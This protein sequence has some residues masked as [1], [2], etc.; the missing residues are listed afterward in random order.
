MVGVA[1]GLSS[2]GF[3]PFVHTF[4]CFSARRALD[5]IFMSCA[6]AK[7]NVKILGSDP[8]VVAALNGGTHTPVSYTH[9]DV[10]K[11]QPLPSLE[12]FVQISSLSHTRLLHIGP[13]SGAQ[14]QR[15]H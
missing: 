1:A 15:F 6:Y 11:R 8:G 7:Q 14:K 10:Y 2:E 4:G 5:Q 12:A 3:I 13:S 9:L